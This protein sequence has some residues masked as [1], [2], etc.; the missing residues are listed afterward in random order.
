MSLRGRLLAAFAYVLVVVIVALEVPLALNLSRRVDSEVRGEAAA[1][2][3]IVAASASGRLSRRSELRRLAVSAAR[4]LR[5]RVIVVDSAGR[6]LADSAGSGLGRASYASR[7]EVAGALVGRTAQGTRRSASLDEELLFTAVPIV[8]AGRR[9]GV[10]RVTQAVDAVRA[11]TRR[12]VLALAGLGLL[13]LTL[14]M[15][16]AWL[17][18]GSLARPLRGLAGA[19]RRVGGGDLSSRAPVTGPREQRETA[20]AF[21]AMAERLAGALT[22]QRDFVANASHQLR[23]PLTGLRLRLEAAGLKS[24]DPG[25]AAELAAAERE[26][27]RL[28][29]LLSG[30]LLLAR[31]DEAPAPARAALDRAAQAAQERWQG[32]AAAQGRELRLDGPADAWVAAGMDELAVILDNLIENALQHSPAPSAVDVRWRRDGD[33]GVLAVIDAGPGPAAGDEERVFERF[34]RR[35]AAGSEGSGLG[36]AIVRTLA[37][38][39]GGT[40]TLRAQPEGGARA[41]V[42]L[43]LVAALPCPDPQLGLSWPA[44]S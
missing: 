10:V 25:V 14:G 7:P 21:N 37:E 20:A 17:L 29:R 36:L 1:G 44:S 41:E 12:D 23:T 13:A 8:S 24:R 27:E 34:V 5:G 26:T 35:A 31:E 28:A 2:A 11:E 40:A 4:D 16:V 22:A 38:R 3:Q 39:R 43:P 15:A 30:L 6:L 19:A 9:Q 33:R 18:A 32:A 42:R